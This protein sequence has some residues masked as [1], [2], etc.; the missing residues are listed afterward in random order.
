VKFN[1]PPSGIQIRMDT[2]LCTFN[3]T[4]N[5]TFVCNGWLGTGNNFPKINISIQPDAVPITTELS[6]WF[7]LKTPTV[8][9]PPVAPVFPNVTRKPTNLTPNSTVVHLPVVLP[10]ATI[11]NATI[12]IVKN[13]TTQ[14]TGASSNINITKIIGNTTDTTSIPNPASTDYSVLVLALVIV[15]VGIAAVWWFIR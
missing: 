12:P 8:Y 3:A 15:I 14:N 5:N 6:V 10:N 7:E 9:V 13:T 2:A 11:P 1:S 4:A